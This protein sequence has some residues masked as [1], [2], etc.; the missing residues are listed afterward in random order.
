MNDFLNELQAWV[1]F[2]VGIGALVMTVA[3]GMAW[4]TNAWPFGRRR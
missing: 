2:F 4:A 1:L 3:L